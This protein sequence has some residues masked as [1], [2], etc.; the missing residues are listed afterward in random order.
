MRKEKKVMEEQEQEK[1]VYINLRDVQNR[2]KSACPE[3]PL[4]LGTDFERGIR[5]GMKL[6]AQLIQ[7]PVDYVLMEPDRATLY[8]S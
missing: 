7:E 6:A 4:D 5:F 1:Q 3:L 8:R 2:I